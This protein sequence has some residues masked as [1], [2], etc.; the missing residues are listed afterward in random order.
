MHD[1]EL[2]SKGFPFGVGFCYFGCPL[3]E[4]TKERNKKYKNQAVP[5]N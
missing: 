1:I 5:I 4:T 3:A 2:Y